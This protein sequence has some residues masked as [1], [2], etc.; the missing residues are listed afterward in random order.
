MASKIGDFREKL[1]HPN[2]NLQRNTNGQSS[3]TRLGWK[4]LWSLDVGDWGFSCPER[5]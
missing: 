3:M 2:S 5:L 4:I 1:Q